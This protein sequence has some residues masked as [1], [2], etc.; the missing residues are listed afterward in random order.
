MYINAFVAKSAIE[1]LNHSKMK[2]QFVLFLLFT[3][4]VFSQNS[5]TK[6]YS[7]YVIFENGVLS[8]E[9]P[10][11]TLIT[12]N[13]KKEGDIKTVSD[14]IEEDYDLYSKFGKEEIDIATNNRE[15]KRANYFSDLAK[16]NVL[17]LIFKDEK[18]IRII[19]GDDYLEYYAFEEAKSSGKD[20]E[21]KTKIN[22][23]ESYPC[24]VQETKIINLE[25]ETIQNSKG[26]INL[27]YNKIYYKNGDKPWMERVF[28]SENKNLKTGNYHYNT[29]YGNVEIDYKNC[30]VRFYDEE[31]KKCFIYNILEVEK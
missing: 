4:L 16:K 27:E 5:Y 29:D 6:K 11:S 30:T 17:I 1:T 24:A 12:F 15:F 8:E 13:Y 18:N 3:N 21:I 9:Y 26:Y 14:G 20:I 10:T 31:N 2:N 23:G 22:R 19:D 28:L 25:K 7:G